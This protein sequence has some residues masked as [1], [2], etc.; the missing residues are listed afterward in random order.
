MQRRTPKGG[1]RLTK[2]VRRGLFLWCGHCE[3]IMDDKEI[4]HADDKKNGE[5]SEYTDQEMIDLRAAIVFMFD[6]GLA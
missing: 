5:Q 2:S 3:A 6:R 4:E 1:C